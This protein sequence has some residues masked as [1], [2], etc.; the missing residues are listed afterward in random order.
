MLGW[1]W[2]RTVLLG[3]K[4][5]HAKAPLLLPTGLFW[6]RLL[7]LCAQ[8]LHLVPA[9]MCPGTVMANIQRKSAKPHPNPLTHGQVPT[10]QWN[11]NTGVLGG[12]NQLLMNVFC[13]KR[14]IQPCMCGR[15]T[16]TV[17]S[18]NKRFFHTEP[19]TVLL[20]SSL[21]Q[22]RDPECRIRDF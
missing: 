8:C 17:Q 22:S 6:I 7:H 14:K 2:W 15:F 19:N 16:A 11:L 4:G 21:Y 10:L 1:P 5:R 20:E 12:K 3:Q 18:H 9:S 13:L